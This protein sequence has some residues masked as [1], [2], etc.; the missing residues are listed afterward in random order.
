M[1]M[2]V[3]ARMILVVMALDSLAVGVCAI[4][5]PD[6]LLT[7]RQLTPPAAAPLPDGAFLWTVL[8]YLNLA[9]ALCLAVAAVWPVR[10]GG[11]ALVPWVG[12]LLSC[13]M[14]LWLLS[15]PVIAP[16]RQRLWYLLGHTGC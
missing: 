8:G 5:R 6:G 15:T 13:G 10:F 12:R 3:N 4:A 1:V 9:N 11:I 2:L 14:W 7:L 16:A